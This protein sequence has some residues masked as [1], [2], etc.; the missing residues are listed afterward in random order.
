MLGTLG[1]AATD[2]PLLLGSGKKE[3]D[4]KGSLPLPQPWV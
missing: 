3:E 1:E 4:G 2:L